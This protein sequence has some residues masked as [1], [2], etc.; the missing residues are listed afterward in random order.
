MSAEL[1]VDTC[2]TPNKKRY[3]S[4]ADARRAERGF[5]DSR[6]GHRERCYPYRCSSG[7]H[8]HLTHHT[9]EA[10]AR[11]FDPETREAGLSPVVNTFEGHGVRHVFTGD[12]PVWVGRDVCDAVGISKYRDALAQLDADERVSVGR[13]HPWRGSDDDRCH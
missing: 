12:E 10:Q 8:W 3:R 2:P 4:Q 6:K 7:G 11:V 9:P 13:G 5:H 1:A